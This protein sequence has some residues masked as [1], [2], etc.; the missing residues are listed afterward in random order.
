MFVRKQVSQNIL[1]VVRRRGMHIVSTAK[2][3]KGMCCRDP[4]DLELYNVRHDGDA[5]TRNLI[6]ELND[7]IYLCRTRASY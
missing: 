2:E 5:I 6:A 4:L 7:H 1:R 3:G